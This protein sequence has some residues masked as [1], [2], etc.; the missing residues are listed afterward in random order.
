MKISILIPTR[1]R[2]S[3][4]LPLIENIHSTVSDPDE[5]EI[6]FG[7]ELHDVA[8]VKLSKE[9]TNPNIKWHIFDTK[10]QKILFSDLYNHLY[11]HV[12]SKIILVA[13]D[14]VKFHYQNWD[15]LIIETFDKYLDKILVVCPRD[16]IQNGAIAPHFFVHNNWVN[17]LGY[18]VPPYFRAWYGDQWVSNVAQAIGRYIYLPDFYLEHFHPIAGKAVPDLT[19]IERDKGVGQDH[20]TWNTTGH[21]RGSDIEKLQTFITNYSKND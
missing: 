13:G 2:S 8:T 21:L 1:L 20:T 14:D 4:L 6:I 15:D 12:T 3:K 11:N 10:K 9:S 17:T 7:I 18:I 16:G 19:S 5:I